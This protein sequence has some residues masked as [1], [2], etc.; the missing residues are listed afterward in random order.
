MSP[1][2]TLLGIA[3]VRRRIVSTIMFRQLLWGVGIFIA[4]SVTAGVASA[5]LLAAGLSAVY[6]GLLLYGLEPAAAGVTTG[7][8][9]LLLIALIAAAFH[10]K[11]RQ[12]QDSIR[13]L[14]KAQA[15]VASRLNDITDSFLDGLFEPE[16]ISKKG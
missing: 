10:L 4:L 9:A 8:L 16:P 6:H 12:L 5:L 11:I 2:G 14:L 15:P 3:M 1:L 13:N 7:G